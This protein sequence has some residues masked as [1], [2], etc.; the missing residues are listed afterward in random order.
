MI[1][2]VSSK[3]T[4]AFNHL[5]Y[6]GSLVEGRKGLKELPNGQKMAGTEPLS[7]PPLYSFV[8]RHRSQIGANFIHRIRRTVLLR[9]CMTAGYAV[10]LKPSPA[11]TR[12]TAAFHL[13][14]RV[15]SSNRPS[16]WTR[17]IRTTYEFQDPFSQHTRTKYKYSN[18]LVIVV[19]SSTLPRYRYTYP[20]A[21]YTFS[22]GLSLYHKFCFTMHRT[23]GARS[24]TIKA[25]I[26]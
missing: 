13:W 5:V 3:S 23:C 2:V 14:S 10:K 11:L 4:Q 20:L 24:N 8:T 17:L 1:K 7:N 16:L 25:L 6:L 12:P 15:G 21:L 19:Y 9:S 18:A 22:S 26:L